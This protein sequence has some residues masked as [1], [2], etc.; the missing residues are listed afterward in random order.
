MKNENQVGGG[1]SF[2][3]ILINEEF[4]HEYHGG[5]KKLLIFEYLLI[6]NLQFEN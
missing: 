2:N 5:T 3:Q 6:E 4:A 1:F